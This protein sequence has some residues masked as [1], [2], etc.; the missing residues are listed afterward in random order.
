MVGI[1]LHTLVMSTFLNDLQIYI[2]SEMS[3]PKTE[4]GAI[5]RQFHSLSSIRFL[6]AQSAR[7]FRTLTSIKIIIL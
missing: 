4:D 3:S 5:G 7:K 1:H 2:G 6:S